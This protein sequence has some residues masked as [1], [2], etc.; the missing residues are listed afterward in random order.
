M[1][2]DRIRVEKGTGL[3]TQAMGFL[4]DCGLKMVRTHSDIRRRRHVQHEK[5]S[6]LVLLPPVCLFPTAHLY[7]C[8]VHL[9]TCK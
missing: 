9:S 7:Q 1:V 8:M 4:T 6:L 5:P 2:D 3:Y